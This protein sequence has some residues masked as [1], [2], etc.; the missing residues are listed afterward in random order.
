MVSLYFL[1][2]HYNYGNSISLSRF[3]GKY[4]IVIYDDTLYEPTT[5]ETILKYTFGILFLLFF[6]FAIY[7]SLLFVINSE[8]ESSL[9]YLQMSSFS[10]LLS[11]IFNYLRMGFTDYSGNAYVDYLRNNNNREIEYSFLPFSL[12][13]TEYQIFLKEKHL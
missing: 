13:E 7:L 10:C 4:P 9:F 3:D 5:K 2:L 8:N 11:I 1:E 12:N 6:C